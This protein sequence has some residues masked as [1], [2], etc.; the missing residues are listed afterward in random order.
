MGGDWLRKAEMKKVTLT[1]VSFVIALTAVFFIDFMPGFSEVTA[2]EQV[3]LNRKSNYDNLI[4]V[5][6]LPNLARLTSKNGK[7]LDL[8]Y[9]Y[10]FAS[11][12]T[13]VLS[14]E[15]W[16]CGTIID[17]PSLRALVTTAR[18]DSAFVIPPNPNSMLPDI[19]KIALLMLVVALV[20]ALMIYNEWLSNNYAGQWTAGGNYT[21]DDPYKLHHDLKKKFGTRH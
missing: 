2:Y 19:L 10:R 16:R 12:N 14:T 13:F 18:F 1:I 9:A 8:Y 17:A 15:S 5:A 3:C 6:D 4:L 7:H 11:K 20:V 21:V